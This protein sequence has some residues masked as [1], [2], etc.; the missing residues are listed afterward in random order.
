MI[1]ELSKYYNTAD[2]IRGLL[3]KISNQIIKRCREKINIDEIHDGDVEKVMTDL[4]ESI[5]CGLEWREIFEKSEVLIAKYSV[6]K[7]HWDI[8][9]KKSVFA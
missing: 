4:D 6:R 9:D 5:Q 8:G 1:F 3:T 2:R 7:E